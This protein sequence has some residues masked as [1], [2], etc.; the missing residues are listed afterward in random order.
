M[1]PTKENGNILKEVVKLARKLAK[2]PSAHEIVKFVCSERQ[3]KNHFDSFKAL[4]DL[5]LETHPELKDII[6]PAKLTFDDLNDYKLD[7]A[8]K[9]T[10]KSNKVVLDNLLTVDSLSR[11]VDNIF[12]NQI[13]P[14]KPV[15]SKKPIQRSLNLTLSDLHFGSDIEAA[16]TGFLTYGK[17]EESRR[18]AEV[19]KQTIDYK[20]QYRLETELHINLLGDLIQAKL[21]DAQDAAPYSEQ[22]CRAIH[23]LSQGLA[24]LGEN[25]PVVTIYCQTGNH[26]RDTKRHP[27]RATTG[28]WDS[29]GTVIYYALK[30]ILAQYKN[31]KFI[32]E[33]TP[34]SIYEVFGHLVLATHG[35][36]F[37][38][39]GN[40]GKSINIKAIEN[41]IN[42]INSTLKGKK[43]SV[44]V[45]GHT[46]C[47]SVSNLNS[48][49][50]LVTN[51][52]LPPSDA[53]AV[54]LG[55]IENR[56]SQT[57]FEMTEKHAVGD[58]RF[59][60]VNEDTDKDKSLDKVINPYESFN[61]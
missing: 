61:E 41:Q 14:V 47:S 54:S 52:P 37:L 20:P 40:P 18:L 35:D 27:K 53:Y 13:K 48:G 56:A 22:L 49:T 23:L 11:F 58:I 51:G 50:I 7:L 42:T 30:K 55:Y 34:Y 3:V 17:I 28:K 5:V 33:K 12:T 39:V 44:V 24:Q 31:V 36:T 29:S 45:V 8:K 60:R 57:L 38:S 59:I 16:E 9:K 6:I 21:H 43:I 25:F 32:I 10:E 15:V 4:K 46:H 26:D 19:I 1:R 2:Y